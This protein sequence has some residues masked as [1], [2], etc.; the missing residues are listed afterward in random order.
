[1]TEAVE[2]QRLPLRYPAVFIKERT[3]FA[4]VFRDIPEAMTCGRTRT[5][6]IH[7]AR[8]AL[9]TALDFYFEDKRIVPMPSTPARDDVLVQ[10][11][12]RAALRLLQFNASLAPRRHTMVRR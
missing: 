10:L 2:P 4:V 11:P 8:D 12:R 5:Q 9:V 1:M 3:G 6:A 7:M